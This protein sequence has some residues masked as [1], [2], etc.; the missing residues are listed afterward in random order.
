MKNYK[1]NRWFKCDLHLHTPASKCFRDKN[2]TPKQWVDRAIEVGLDCVAVTDHNTG[3]SIDE[4]K[5]AAEG[6]ELTVFPGVEITC[7]TSK[8]H[9]LILFDVSK[10]TSDIEDFLIKADIKRKNFG[11]EEGTTI[12]NIFDIAELANKDG[13]LVIPAHI[14]E[15]SGLGSLSVDNLKKF[16]KL[17]NINAVQVVHKKFTDKNLKTIGNSEFKEYLK[18]Y[19]SEPTPSID[20]STIKEW[21][22]PVKFAYES[23]LAILTFSDNPH[24]PNNPKHGLY[25]IGTRY[26]WIKMDEVP[27]L[28]G[29]RQAFLLPKFR[30]KNDFEATKTPFET[31]SLWI[32]SLKVYDNIIVKKE[33]PFEI[34]F[35]PQLNSIIGGRGSG[36][37]S[38]LRF[39]RG[40]FN[41]TEEIRS[42]NEVINDHVSFYRKEEGK[43]KKGVFSE[44][45]TIEI[46]FIRDKILHKILAKNINSS[47]EQDILI[48]QFDNFLNNWIE[49]EDVGYINFFN[50]E[51]YSQKQI[52]EIAQEPNA[53][54]KIIDRSINGIAHLK[55]EREYTKKLFLEKSAAI[56]R[57]EQLIKNKGQKETILKDLKIRIDA[58]QKSGIAQLLNTK[59]K[60]TDQGKVIRSLIATPSPKARH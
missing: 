49:I 34:E 30:I 22:T 29:L 1:G 24:E 25:G 57:A 4:I 44:Y 8:I 54:R 56:R 12:K 16:Y 55:D 13:A 32:K 7:D 21:F 2:V 20:D 31:P 35:N 39:I 6:T 41:N 46:E 9:L 19:Y 37:S 18:N 33:I 59:E 27:T 48:M 53:L 50:F 17:E 51:H 28:E 3:L 43:P 11:E 38:V 58:F 60:F 42:I 47:S 23:N 10:S 15:Y 14:D 45:S 5:T 52:Y 36:K 40:V 26:T